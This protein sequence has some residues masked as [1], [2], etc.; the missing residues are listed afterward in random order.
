MDFVPLNEPGLG[1]EYRNAIL[2][3]VQ[4]RKVETVGKDK[5][6]ALDTSQ[7]SEHWLLLEDCATRA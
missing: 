5:I 6:H 7:K 1:T 3:R 4:G 2:D